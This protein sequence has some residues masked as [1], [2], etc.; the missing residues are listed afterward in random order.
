MPSKGSP[1]NR[2][3]RFVG[4]G[5]A[6]ERNTS[7]HYAIR[8]NI[9]VSDSS[10]HHLPDR[11]NITLSRQRYIIIT[12]ESRGRPKYENLKHSQRMLEAP[13]S[14]GRA[15]RFPPPYEIYSIFVPQPEQKGALFATSALQFGQS[16]VSVIEAPHEAQ[17]F[18]FASTAAPHFGH[19]FSC[20]APQAGQNV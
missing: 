1:A 17:N 18:L 19:V 12:V 3:Q 11:A 15:E 2:E 10:Q 5:P 20:F 14:A 7:H 8:H 13:Y 4:I 9:T 6:R 16:F